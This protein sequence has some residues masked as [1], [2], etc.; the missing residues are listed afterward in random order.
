MSDPA[1]PQRS[2][3]LLAESPYFDATRL[4]VVPPGGQPR[5][6]GV[7]ASMRL[8]ERFGISEQHP[9]SPPATP[10]AAWM[11][12]PLMRWD[13]DVWLEGSHAANI[14]PPDDCILAM[15]HF[16]FGPDSL[17]RI[18]SAI[19]WKAHANNGA[20]YH[21]YARLLQRMQASGQGFVG[22]DSRR[23]ESNADL[24]AAGLMV[25]P[26]ELASG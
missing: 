19:S 1:R 26:A 25:V 18:A 11:K 2:K 12:T 17:R 10:P 13:D 14:L 23:F 15:A 7:G 8:F 22:Q 3:D 16:K 9:A 20:K 6:V 5:R 21:F 24:V 4:L